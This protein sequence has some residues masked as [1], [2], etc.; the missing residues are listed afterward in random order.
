[1]QSLTLIK[2][3]FFR[4]RKGTKAICAAG[5]GNL[6]IQGTMSRYYSPYEGLR[7]TG[8]CLCLGLPPCLWV[9]RL[10]LKV[11]KTWKN[12]NDTRRW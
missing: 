9:F 5:E 12:L 7:V 8:A 11:G 10:S 2:K 3:A 4:D 6:K 1:M